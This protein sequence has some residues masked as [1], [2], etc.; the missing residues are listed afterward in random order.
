VPPPTLVRRN[1]TLPDETPGFQ[2]IES[3]VDSVDGQIGQVREQRNR[4]EAAV[5]NSGDSSAIGR[6]LVVS[7]GS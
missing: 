1:L 4:G 7:E 2:I 6:L 5:N 3:V